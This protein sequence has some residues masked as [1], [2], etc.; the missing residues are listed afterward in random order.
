[1][2][3]TDKLKSHVLKEYERLPEIRFN[4]NEKKILLNGKVYASMQ[5][6]KQDS[7]LEL[8]K[9]IIK[10][11]CF[12]SIAYELY[13]PQDRLLDWQ[14]A[15]VLKNM[16]DY[17]KEIKTNFFIAKRVIQNRKAHKLAK[18]K[19]SERHLNQFHFC[20]ENIVLD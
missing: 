5:Y 10:L 17:I 20:L 2:S 4:L 14:D 16:I 6:K 7:F 19:N 3:F 9:D 15:R 11:N 12:G 18:C 8:V 1:M 13:K